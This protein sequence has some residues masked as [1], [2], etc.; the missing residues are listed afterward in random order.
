MKKQQNAR[1]LHDISP[2]KNSNAQLSDPKTG[3]IHFW[4]PG[5][6]RR[7]PH[8]VASPAAATTAAALTAALAVA[9]AT[10]TIVAAAAASAAV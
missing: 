2:N 7:R 1:I 4:S 9:A 3:A 10:S 5:G 8:R 6:V